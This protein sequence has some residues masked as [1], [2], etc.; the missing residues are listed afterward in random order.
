MHRLRLLL[1][2]LSVRRA[3]VSKGRQFRLTRQDGQV[4]LLRRRRR[5]RSPRVAPRNTRNTDRTVSAKAN[6]HC[7]PRCARPN[8]CWPGMATSLRRSMESGFASAATARVPGAGRQPITRTSRPEQAD[9]DHCRR[10]SDRGDQN[11][12][13]VMTFLARIRLVTIRP[14]IARHCCGACVRPKARSGWCSKPGCQRHR[15]AHAA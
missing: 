1:L 8:L 14:D 12:V 11:K 15:P 6:C 5:A 10:R 7:V 4:H 13:I 3:A 9:F 2:C